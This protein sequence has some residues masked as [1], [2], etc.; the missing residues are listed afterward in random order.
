MNRDQNIR[1]I[2]WIVL[3]LNLIVAGAK[4]FYGHLTGSLSMTADG[5]HSAFDG[6][7]N[8]IL[9]IGNWAACQPPNEKHPYGHRKYE[10]FA[11]FGIS[12]LLFLTCFHI[13]QDSYQRTLNPLPTTVTVIS[14]G[15]MLVTMA[16]NY[17]VMKWEQ[18]QGRVLKSDSLIADSLHT[19]SDIF[20]SL[21]VLVSL[22]A[23]KVGFPVLDPIIAVIIAGFIGKTGLEILVEVSS[24][25]SDSSRINARDIHQIAMRLPG[26][27]NCHGVRTRGS[28]NH[29]Y[30][31]FHIDVAPDMHINDAHALAHDIEALIKKEHAEV[32][33]VVIHVEPHSH[34]LST[35]NCES[36]TADPRSPFSGDRR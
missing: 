28:T 18:S 34:D 13:L 5:F 29:I 8:I 30:V 2:L 19:R 32:V 27:K 22:F 35:S 3:F 9:L 15:V 12:V 14:F 16:I 4:L 33:D 6:A 21:S 1:Q 31:D 36:K 17:G 23:V 7:S 10:T 20:T 25:L 24:V 11:S 26:V